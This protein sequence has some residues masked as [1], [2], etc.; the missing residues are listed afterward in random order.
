MLRFRS[1]LVD[2]GPALFILVHTGFFL[3]FRL[4]GVAR[5]RK[6]S[7][8]PPD[9]MRTGDVAMAQGCDLAALAGC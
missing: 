2:S 9:V 6:T 3:P 4:F 7:M 1:I 8:R 5:S